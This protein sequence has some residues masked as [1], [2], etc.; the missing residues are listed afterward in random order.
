MYTLNEQDVEILKAAT[1]LVWAKGVH[2]PQQSNVAN[3]LTQLTGR[4]VQAV[5]KPKEPML[6][7]VKEESRGG[8]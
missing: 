4:A 2:D 7:K 3:A 1:E 6:K 8:E 5:P